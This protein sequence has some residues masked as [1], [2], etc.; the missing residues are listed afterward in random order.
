MF[1]K[2]DPV[3]KTQLGFNLDHQ[4]HLYKIMNVL[5]FFFILPRLIGGKIQKRLKLKT[6]YSIPLYPQR[7]K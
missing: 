1:I 6:T 7:C 5:R 2:K 3:P 4:L